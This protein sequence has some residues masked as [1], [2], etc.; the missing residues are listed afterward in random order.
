MPDP[1]WFDRPAPQLA[2]LLLGATLAHGPCAGIITETEAYGPDD[3]ASHSFRGPTARNA[4][5]FGPPGSVYVYRIYGMHWCVNIVGPRGH[6]VQIRALRP[7]LGLERLTQRRGPGRPLCK[8]PGMLAQALG[9]TG[10][11]DATPLGAPI[12]LTPAD[13]QPHVTG[14]RIG[15][16]KAADWPHRYGLARAQADWSRPFPRA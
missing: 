1:G 3:P 12:T 5:M 11:L 4:A 6:A 7:S 15:I 16:T 10:A 13:T 9:I 2:P 14:P 8:G